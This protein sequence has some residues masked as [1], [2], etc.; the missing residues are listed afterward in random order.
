MRG[1]LIGPHRRIHG[2]HVVD[3]AERLDEQVRDVD[4]AREL[5]PRDRRLT[6]Q[7]L[8]HLDQRRA[9]RDRRRRRE[10]HV[11]AVGAADGRALDDAVLL[12]ILAREDAAVAGQIVDHPP[13]QIAAIERARPVHR[14]EAQRGGQIGVDEP[15]ARLR[16]APAGQEQGP[17]AGVTRGRGLAL[18]DRRGQ[19]AVEHEARGG[20]VDRRRDQVGP[21]DAA[22]AVVA[23]QVIHAG[24]DARDV[25][26][27]RAVID[28]P[29]VAQDRRIVERRRGRRLILEVDDDRRLRSGAPHQRHPVA[30]DAR[31]VGLDH[32]ERERRGDGGVDGVAAGAQGAGAGLGRQRMGRDDDPA[33]AGDRRPDRRRLGDQR[34]GDVLERRVVG[35]RGGPGPETVAQ[36]PPGRRRSRRPDWPGRSARPRPRRRWRGGAPATWR[37]R[38]G[39]AATSHRAAPGRRGTAPRDRSARGTSAR[40]CRRRAAADRCSR[41]PARR[42]P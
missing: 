10:H 29:P 25:E 26:G 31:G 14:D 38:R 5:R 4:V 27:G 1:A 7:R 30:A 13:R 22:A 35:G 34:V 37:P 39:A 11:A 36:R 8:Q 18:G 40:W 32:A 19:R 23:V 24:D 2:P 20:V 3:V 12:E 16:Q 42:D 28:E 21:R 9:G 15:I 41:D 33:A 6:I 17:R